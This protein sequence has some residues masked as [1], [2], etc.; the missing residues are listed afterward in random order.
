MT[1]DLYN[2][3]DLLKRKPGKNRYSEVFYSFIYLIGCDSDG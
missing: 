2:T 1:N 3:N